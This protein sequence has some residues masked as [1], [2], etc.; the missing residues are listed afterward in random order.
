MPTN[1]AFIK[2]GTLAQNFTFENQR[3]T[4]NISP[5]LKMSNVMFDVCITEYP[6]SIMKLGI[7]LISSVNEFRSNIMSS[8]LKFF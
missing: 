6:A 3:F 7:S 1:L 2:I 8:V 4:A 5:Y